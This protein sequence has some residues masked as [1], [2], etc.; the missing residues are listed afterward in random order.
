MNINFLLFIAYIHSFIHTY[1]HTPFC[2]A[3]CRCKSSA[4]RETEPVERVFHILHRSIS[5]AR[6]PCW[7][8][9]FDSVGNTKCTTAIVFYP[10][11]MH[12]T[13]TLGRFEVRVCW[14]LLS[15]FS[16]LN[17]FIAH[18]VCRLNVFTVH[19]YIHMLHAYLR[20]WPVD[21]LADRLPLV[22]VLFMVSQQQRIFPRIPCARPTAAHSRSEIHTQVDSPARD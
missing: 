20:S 17:F 11:F 21:K 22:S 13:Q 12:S 7:R 19:T 6:S 5:T 2:R 8:S 10:V 18:R 4:A 14:K 16:V 15:H 3:F 1:I 9:V